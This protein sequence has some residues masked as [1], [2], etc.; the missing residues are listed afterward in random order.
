MSALEE[1]LFLHSVGLAH[2][3]G[4][5]TETCLAPGG[6]GVG[7]VQAC[8]QRFFVYVSPEGRGRVKGS[9]PSP[10]VEPFL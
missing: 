10:A 4:S 5:S 8:A 2:L 9:G 1:Q 6:S 7:V 3:G